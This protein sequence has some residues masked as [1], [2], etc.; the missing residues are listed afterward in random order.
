MAGD[1]GHEDADKQPNKSQPQ[2]T[3][4]CRHK[5]IAAKFEIKSALK[6]K[7]SY[8]NVYP[9]KQLDVCF[10]NLFSEVTRLTK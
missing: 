3:D 2:C 9:T 4:F 1:N 8:K 7:N 6:I 10:L 5:H